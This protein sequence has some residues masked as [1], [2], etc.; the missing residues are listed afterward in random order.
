[1]HKNIILWISAAVITFIVG[2]FNSVTGDDLPLS[3]TF[4]IG[5]KKVTYK[6]DTFYDGPQPMP[7]L[8]RT[9][10]D[11]V[12][13]LLIF[14]TDINTVWDTVVMKRKRETLEGKIEFGN[15]PVE[16]EYNAVLKKDGKIYRVP[17]QGTV[18]IKV[19]GVTSSTVK[20]LFWF[21]LLFALFLSTRTGLEYFAETHN[22]KKHGIFTAIFFILYGFVVSPLLL[23]Y[24]CGVL[25]KRIPSPAEIV[26]PE[27]FILPVLW[28]T[29]LILMFN[30]RNQKITALVT[31]VITIMLFIL[32]H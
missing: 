5:G 9:D 14:R 29:A 23:T 8:I 18:K 31:S 22:E 27:Y 32:I 13:G 20:G 10:A 25:D 19:E 17:N 26:N 7:V 24:R 3:G 15:V 11:S 21:C 4:G 30:S 6:F 1:M 2:Y 28:I 12:S 16:A